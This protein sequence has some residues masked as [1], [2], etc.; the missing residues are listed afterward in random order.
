MAR[1]VDDPGVEASAR[2]VRS[3]AIHD[4]RSCTASLAGV[5]MS[6]GMVRRHSV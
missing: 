4:R 6:F 5:P 2:T 3:S 1:L